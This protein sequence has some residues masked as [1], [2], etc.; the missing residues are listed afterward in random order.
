V[1]ELNGAMEATTPSGF[2]FNPAF[3][4]ATLLRAVLLRKLIVV[5]TGKFSKL[6]AFSTSG[7]CFIY[8]L[9]HFPHERSWQV[10]SGFFPACCYSDKTSDPFF[11][12]HG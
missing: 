1:R 11:N 7:S 6:N 8:R 9:P 4:A 2:V 3:N 10:P 12:G 5:M